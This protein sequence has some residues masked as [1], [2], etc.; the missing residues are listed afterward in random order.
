MGPFRKGLEVGE[1]T[2]CG[3]E[4]P[5][6]ARKRGPESAQCSVNGFQPQEGVQ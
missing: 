6:T 4:G 3:P 1:G 2:G 5:S